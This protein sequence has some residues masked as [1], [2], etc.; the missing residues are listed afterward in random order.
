MYGAVFRFD[1]TKTYTLNY[2]YYTKMLGGIMLIVIRA[3]CFLGGLDT[4]LFHICA[5]FNNKLTTF[6]VNLGFII[7]QKNKI[8]LLVCEIIFYD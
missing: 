4:L 2:C 7:N 1:R 3:L 5:V 6:A 8:F